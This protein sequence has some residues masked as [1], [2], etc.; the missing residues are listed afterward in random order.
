MTPPT[1]AERRRAAL[2]GLGSAAH[3]LVDDRVGVLHAVEEIRLPAGA[4]AFFQT[5]AQIGDTTAL[6]YPATLGIASAASADREEAA[7]RAVARAV[8]LYCAALYEGDHLPLFSFQSAPVATV[9][10]E[11][12]ALFSPAQYVSPEFPYR[13][14]DARSTV[15]WTP[16][17]DPADGET[18]HAPAATVFLPYR[19]RIG[20]GETP[21][22]PA[23]STGLA[24][25]SGPEEAAVAAICDAMECDAAAIAW[26]ARLALPR[27]R[28]ETLGDRAYDLVERL[29]RSVGEVTLLDARTDLG[30]PAFLGVLRGRHPGPPAAVFSAACDPSPERAAERC[31]DELALAWRHGWMVG[32]GLPGLD[33]GPGSEHVLTQVDHLG[34]WCDPA[35]LPLAGFLLESP[36]RVELGEIADLST[37]DPTADLGRLVEQLEAASLRVLLAD[38][39]TPDVRLA[40][41][42]AV[43]AVVP[44]LHPLFMGHATRALGGVRLHEVPRRLGRPVLEPGAGDNPAPHPFVRQGV[45]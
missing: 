43:R 15:A 3:L 36:E 19:A 28:I 40:G 5:A 29:E 32:S 26:Q 12:F 41:L 24:C 31:L 17:T 11:E 14:F 44:G 16:A 25:G 2:R 9:P 45:G 38:L 20:A 7:A 34:F 33:P 8:A 23:T 35:H 13:P 30:V 42:T 21:I 4:P 10:P 6:S 22:A 39:T 1:V 18:R 37:G 27:V